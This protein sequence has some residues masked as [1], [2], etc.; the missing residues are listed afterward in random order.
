MSLCR[1]SLFFYHRFS[2][3]L[4]V[5]VRLFFVRFWRWVILN[6][7]RRGPPHIFGMDCTFN[8]WASVCLCGL[9]FHPFKLV[10]RVHL[11]RN[12]TIFSAGVLIHLVVF[13]LWFVLVVNRHH[14]A[15]SHTLRL[16]ASSVV[17][18]SDFYSSFTFQFLSLGLLVN[19][20]RMVWRHRSV[21]IS[22]YRPVGSW[23][24]YPRNT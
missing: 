21:S 9:Y 13:W 7:R 14:F 3:F 19:T 24:P 1:P 22:V 11:I 18:N 10:V 5:L 12:S 15:F 6:W 23:Y 4:M 16:V 2:I 17:T 8:L 20:P